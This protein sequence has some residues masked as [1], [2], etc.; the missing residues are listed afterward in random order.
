M[1]Q[2]VRTCCYGTG[3]VATA[4]MVAVVVVPVVAE[5]AEAATVPGAAAVLAATANRRP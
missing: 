4:V 3:G 5:P 1:G 2:R